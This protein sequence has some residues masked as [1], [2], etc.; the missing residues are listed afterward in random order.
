[1]SLP[2]QRPPAEPESQLLTL[3]EQPAR[4]PL[5]VR[6]QAE[7]FV[8]FARTIF[9]LLEKYRDRLA[10]VYC[11]D[12][13]RPA[14]DPVRL[15]GVLVLQFVLRVPDRQAAEAVQYDQRWRLALHLVAQDV[16]FDPSLLTVFR[17][18][19]VG[20]A[21]ERLAL[22]AVLDHL[23]EHGWLPKRSR[24][25]LD[26][27]HV[28]GLLSAMNRLECARETIRLLLEDVEADGKLP[29][30][31]SEYWERYVENKL[32]PRARAPA[33]ES[34]F[35]QAGRDMLT[36]WEYAAGYWSIVARD[37]FVL[38][39]RVF[40]ENYVLD[41][42]GEAQKTRAQPTGAV[43]NPHE[44]EAQWSSKST[45]KDKTW[46]GYK[47]QVAETVQEQPRAA[48]EPTAN[49]LT[50][51]VTQN[52][53]AS[54]KAGMALVLTEQHQLGLKAPSALYV[55]GAYVSSEALKDA[56]EQGR[57]L[58]GPAP[59]SPDR[60]KVFTVEAF[61]VHVEERYALCP[62]GRCSSNCSRLAVQNTGKIDYR[63]EWSK[64][65]CRACPLREQCVSAGQ[66]HR[67]FVVGEL[68]SLL[69][70]RRR[71]M[72]TVAFKQEMRRRNGIEG[73]QSELVRGY[74]L[75][76]ARYRGQAKVRLQ[77]YLIGAACNIR[78][79]FRR[80]AWETKQTLKAQ[81]LLVVGVAG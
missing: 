15:L 18:R 72:Q 44:P 51:V 49:F 71:E 78:R 32:D 30:E 61:D 5:A 16:V 26:S 53:P 77:N 75:R 76:Q 60:G 23:V 22:E 11:A 43:H 12:N 80:I 58:R 37:A 20:G 59:A 28:R 79:L 2:R 50:A 19:L 29:V 21:Q 9:P 1:M 6:R 66:D 47:V 27:T 40:L 52:A 25:R 63:I 8:F 33:L 62:A 55:D 7:F 42:G 13:G 70:E 14:W 65:V 67:T 34:K 81:E 64:K 4:V 57:E 35:A 54:Y 74:G 73:T 17:N 3:F 36:I 69:Q 56:R 46:V 31:W 41:A 39:Q 10:M 68:H 48:G 24:Q 45:T 38:L